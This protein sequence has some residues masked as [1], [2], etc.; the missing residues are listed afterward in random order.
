MKAHEIMKKL[1]DSCHE[2]LQQ[3]QD[4]LKAGDPDREV[5]K[6][7]TTMF[8]TV[9]VIRQAAA[10]G[11]DLLIV[12]EPLYF[13]HCDN[14]SEE[15]VETEKRRLVEE[16]GMTIYRFHDYSHNVL[17]DVICKG[18]LD[19]VQ[20]DG[21]VVEWGYCLARVRLNN[22]MTPKQVAELLRDRLQLQNVRLCG[23]MDFETQDV[24]FIPGCAWWDEL[25]KFDNRIFILGEICEWA[26][27]EYVRD[28]A[29]LGHNK[30]MIILGHVGSEREAMRFVANDLA[31]AYP[32]IKVRYFQTEE[33]FFPL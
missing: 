19:G 29:A 26:T 21:E 2:P 14:H 17:P 18:I 23:N 27:A 22:A 11:A 12:H 7:A 33:S 20:F 1:Y 31:Q 6:I 10:W 9:D 30:A 32:Q 28:A 13:N 3:T 24:S 4:V 16:S 8:P 25:K 5:R 15:S